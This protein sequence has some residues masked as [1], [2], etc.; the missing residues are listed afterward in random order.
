MA[1]GTSEVTVL[2]QATAY[3]VFMSDGMQ[4]RR[5]GITQILDYKGDLLYDFW[6]D[7]PPAERVLTKEASD[8]MNQI[9]TQVPEWGTGRR[10]KLDG[11]K[12]AGKTGTTQAY[13]DAWFCGYTGNFS[14][15]VWFGN[16]DYTSTNRMTGGSLPAMTFKRIMEYAHQGIELK[17]IPGIEDPL[18]DPDAAAEAT[19]AANAANA[20]DGYVPPVRPRTLSAQTTAL[21]RELIETFRSTE[22]LKAAGEKLAAAQTQVP[23]TTK[24]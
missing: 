11:I 20:E 6:R 8:S 17:P 4:S 12:T 15:A 13:R 2:D 10:A 5:H 3:G 1:L 24:Q 9:L 16:D 23:Q 14:T 21:L 22:P 7:E 18:P 19:I